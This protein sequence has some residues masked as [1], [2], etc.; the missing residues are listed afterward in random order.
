MGS[1]GRPYGERSG[2]QASGPSHQAPTASGCSG[3]VGGVGDP[4]RHAQITFDS[5]RVI[6][7]LPE[8]LW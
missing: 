5:I 3:R 6:A 7:D 1:V 8:A 2:T 4:L